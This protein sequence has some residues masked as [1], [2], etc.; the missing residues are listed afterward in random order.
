M[1]AKLSSPG[2]LLDAFQH[3]DHMHVGAGLFADEPQMVV[4]VLR[5]DRRSQQGTGLSRERVDRPE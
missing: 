1:R 5:I 2:S 3:Q 4:H